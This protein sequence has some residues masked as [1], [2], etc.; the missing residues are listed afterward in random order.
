MCQTFGIMGV[1]TGIW[2][3]L[4]G[5]LIGSTSS[6]SSTLILQSLSYFCPC[7]Q[8]LEISQSIH[9]AI[10][11]INEISTFSFISQVSSLVLLFSDLWHEKYTWLFLFGC[12]VSTLC[13]S[14]IILCLSSSRQICVFQIHAK[15]LFCAFWLPTLSV[16]YICALHIMN[17]FEGQPAF[18]SLPLEVHPV[19]SFDRLK[20]AYLKSLITKLITFNL[21]VVQKHNK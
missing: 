11:E 15:L 8:Y 21:P 1:F 9:Q 10:N 16:M 13:I 20:P 17:F 3:F 6:R 19:I 18:L 2:Y 7:S 5:R 12:F 4:I 14:F